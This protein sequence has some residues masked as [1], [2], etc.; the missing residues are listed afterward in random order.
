MKRIRFG[1]KIAVGFCGILL[2]ISTLTSPAFAKSA[3]KATLQDVLDAIVALQNSVNNLE[4]SQGNMPPAWYKILPS[5]QR[6]LLVMGDK[7]VLDRETGLV[8]E[9]SP[10]HPCL[11]SFCTALETGTRSWFLA[12]DLCRSLTVGGRMGWRLPTIE[13]LMSLVD[14]T[15][16]N[17]AL[18]DG[19]PFSNVQLDWWYW[20]ASSSHKGA[21][22]GWVMRFLDGAVND[23]FKPAECFVWCVRGGQGVDPQ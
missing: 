18:P 5:G 14:P 9:K 11:E 1:T 16:V 3:P 10:L 12:E 13:E 8:W 17:P 22:I 2:I 19:H 4:S 23:A 6:F 15:Q 20:S 21:D 7:A